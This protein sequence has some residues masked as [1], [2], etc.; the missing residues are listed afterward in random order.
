[1]GLHPFKPS[2][3][4]AALLAQLDS[5]HRRPHARGLETTYALPCNTQNCQ[6]KRQPPPEPEPVP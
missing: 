1:M 4:A 5:P 6:R 2:L 3:S